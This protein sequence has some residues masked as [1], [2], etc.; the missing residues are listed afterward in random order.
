MMKLTRFKLQKLHSLPPLPSPADIRYGCE[1]SQP[2]HEVTAHKDVR[3]RYLPRPARAALAMMVMLTSGA[4][5]MACRSPASAP[6]AS[7]PRSAV[8]LLIQA[9][10]AINPDD[11]GQPW[12]TALTIYQLRG[13]PEAPDHEPLDLAAL[14]AAGAAAGD[15]AFGELL[16]A[17]RDYTAFPDTRA[18]IVIPLAPEATHLVAVAH[19]REPLGE[20]AHLVYPVPDARAADPCFYLGLERS[21]L[22]GGEFPPPGFEPAAFA[23]ACPPPVASAPGPKASSHVP[24]DMPAKPL[25]ARDAPTRPPVPEDMSTKPPARDAP[26]RPPVP[27]DMS[28]K[29][30]PARDAPARLP[31]PEDMSRAAPAP[32]PSPRAR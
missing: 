30:L 14:Q 27:E 2:H 16:V 3:R 4:G 28:A 31:V 7:A 32:D 20:A 29:P 1:Q 8:Q 21:E 12:P 6:P 15:A 25:L 9:G 19:F 22:D 10:P 5:L 11:D 23:T 13:D 26:A 17:K 18:R 24:E